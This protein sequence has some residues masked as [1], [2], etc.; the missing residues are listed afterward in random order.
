MALNAIRDLVRSMLTSKPVYTTDFIVE[1]LARLDRPAT[2]AEIRE[3]LQEANFRMKNASLNWTLTNLNTAGRIRRVRR[4]VY[5][6]LTLKQRPNPVQAPN[7]ATT[8]QLRE[9]LETQVPQFA[10]VIAMRVALRVL[11]LACDILVMKEFPRT[12]GLKAI[13]T[14]FRAA[15]ISWVA[16]NY[17]TA[18]IGSSADEAGTAAAYYAREYADAALDAI[19]HGVIANVHSSAAA[20]YAGVT[21][22]H[23]AQA[24]DTVVGPNELWASINADVMWLSENGASEP[25]ISAVGLASRR[26]WLEDVRGSDK[27]T[28]NFPLWARK[29]WDEFKKTDAITGADFD[30]WIKWYESRLRGSRLGGF[31]PS[32]DMEASIALDFYI[33]SLSETFWSREAIE[34]NRDIRRWIEEKGTTNVSGPVVEPPPGP[35]PQYR[36]RNGKLSEDISRPAEGESQRQAGLHRRLSADAAKLADSL[37]RAVNRYPELA[38]AAREYAEILKAN[39]S[40]I[41]VSGVWSVGG[42]LATF[43]RS[44]QE[45]NIA[46]TMT[47]P[48]EPQL[49]ASLQNVVRQHGAFI[50]GFNEGRDLIQ[51]ADEFT[52]DTA[53]LREIEE[54]GSVLLNELTENRDLV[55]DRTRQLHRPVRDTVAEFGWASSRV[56]YSAY[57]IVRNGVHAMIKFAV[58]SDPNIGELLAILAGV[59]VLAGDPNADFIRAAI[60]VLQQYGSQLLAFFNHSPEMRAYVE[61]ALHILE[62]DHGSSN[63]PLT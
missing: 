59:S 35:G 51:R 49:D 28:V 21:V 63:R 15:S 7:I 25:K 18:N 36:P 32:L 20:D 14:M 39:I 58:G 2:T 13:L 57:L 40:E 46:R 60:P 3:A 37:Q 11:P 62:V 12:T 53:R 5:E 1:F 29:E 26:L 45:Q 42:A 48:L 6:S 10:Q 50:M 43:A 31:S 23:A 30:F 54:S 41:D 16:N 56:G 61:W 52:I 55:D 34:I 9:W 44:Y 47:E 24:A 19:A 17:P 4:G 27:Y 22:A 8:F 33:A 38:G